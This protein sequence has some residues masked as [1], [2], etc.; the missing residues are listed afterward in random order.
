MPSRGAVE[1]DQEPN[2]S[3]ASEQAF[4]AGDNQPKPCDVA[5]RDGGSWMMTLLRWLSP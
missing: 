5:Q 4:P 2:R 3:R 1:R